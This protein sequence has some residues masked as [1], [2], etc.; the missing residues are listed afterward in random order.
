MASAR[1]QAALAVLLAA[2][3]GF[4]HRTTR[5]RVE[6]DDEST[7]LLTGGAP[8]ILALW[9]ERLPPMVCQWTRFPDRARAP[10]LPLHF[11]ISGHRDG[12]LIAATAARIGVAS[13]AGSTSRGGAAA[14]AAML[15]LLR[16]GQACVGITPDGPRG[17]RRVAQPGVAALAA[18]SGAPVVPAAAATR[19]QFRLGSWDR[20]MLSL[21]FGR[22]CLVVGP[23]V[24]VAREAPQ[25]T[26]LAAIGA[27]LDAA[28]ARADCAVG[29]A[30]Q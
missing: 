8:F 15:A 22:G 4:V 23:P 21:P 27:A 3:L 16:S 11:V 6:M 9:H 12:R 17:P 13:V 25:A 29:L 5:W 14:L 24:A 18:I 2:W 26:A 7:A 1:M 20:M 30:A 19:H 10:V 28:C